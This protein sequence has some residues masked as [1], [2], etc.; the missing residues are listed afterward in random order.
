MRLNKIEE[1]FAERAIIKNNIF[2]LASSDAIDFIIECQRQNIKILGVDAFYLVQENIRPIME[3]SIDFT[4][5]SYIE[6]N[7]SNYDVARTIIEN[8]RGSYFEIVI[9]S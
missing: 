1:L 8:T 9:D 5:G 2:L 4:S 6:K 7:I 3:K